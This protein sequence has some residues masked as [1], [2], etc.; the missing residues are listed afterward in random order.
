MSLRELV[1][2][3]KAFPLD[4]PN[5]DIPQKQSRPE[6]HLPYAQCGSQDPGPQT[7]Q[8]N[9]TQPPQN[10]LQKCADPASSQGERQGLS[11]GRGFVRAAPGARGGAAGAFVGVGP[12]R[13]HKISYYGRG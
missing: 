1:F 13:G 9:H 12:T 2:R 11:L 7:S 4:P 10:R 6:P 8:L 3:P 5:P